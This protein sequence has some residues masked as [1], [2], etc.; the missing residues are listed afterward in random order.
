MKLANLIGIHIFMVLA[1]IY[2]WM[3]TTLHINQIF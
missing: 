1:N 3:G 2:K